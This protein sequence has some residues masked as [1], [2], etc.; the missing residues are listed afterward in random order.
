M[1]NSIIYEML[2][3]IHI[4]DYRDT[5]YQEKNNFAKWVSETKDELEKNFDKTQLELI[6]KY[7]NRIRTREEYIYYQ[8]GV[9]I[10]D[11]G[12]K[13]GMELCKAFEEIEEE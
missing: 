9:K 1:K 5:L 4:N 13:I 12:I 11:Y 2:D 3:I 7:E 6:E 8:M 10:L